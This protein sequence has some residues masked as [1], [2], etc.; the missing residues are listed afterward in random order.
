MQ[1]F[2]VVKPG[3]TPRDLGILIRVLNFYIL[4]LVLNVLCTRA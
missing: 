4:T 3:D 2:T 1:I